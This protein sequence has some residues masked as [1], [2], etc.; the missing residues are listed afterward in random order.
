ML[1]RYVQWRRKREY[2]AALKD[3]KAIAKEEYPYAQKALARVDNLAQTLRQRM[4]DILD[5]TAELQGTATTEAQ[6]KLA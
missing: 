3:C 6:E 1:R 2:K 5:G 4:D